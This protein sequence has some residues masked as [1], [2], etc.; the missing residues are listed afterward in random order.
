[1]IRILEEV[2]LWC[3]FVAQAATLLVIVPRFSCWAHD[4]LL[5]GRSRRRNCPGCGRAHPVDGRHQ[6]RRSMR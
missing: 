3:N 1:M 6:P 4:V 5:W 2:A